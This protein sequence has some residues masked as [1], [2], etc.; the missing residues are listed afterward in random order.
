[1]LTFLPTRTEGR[2]VVLVGIDFSDTSR[3]ALDTAR[4]IART[5]TEPELH[6][7]HVLPTPG[8]VGPNEP[9]GLIETALTA[10]L[11][12]A[13]DELD[14]LAS[15]VLGDPGVRVG[16]HVRIGVPDHE[17]VQA[18]VDLDA[19]L[20]VIGTHGRTGLGRLL[21]GSVAE[22][23]V[24]RAP[25]AVLT[26]KADTAALAPEV[27]PPCTECLATQRATK[28]KTLWCPQHAQKHPRAHVWHE[29]PAG[30]GVGSQ[31][32]RPGE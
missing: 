9:T 19:D 8:P 29:S 18:A 30:F 13:R 2:A 20:I 27:L 7:V 24:R 14:R 22:Q 21:L 16:G 26:V 1:M 12:R 23:V 28:G 11:D 3:K 25:C 32:F 4:A 31:S 6:L 5:Q 10:S 15:E 17:L